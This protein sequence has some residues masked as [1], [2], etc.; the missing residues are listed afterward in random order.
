[1]THPARPALALGRRRTPEAR[2]WLFMRVSG[3]LL[4]LLVVGHLLDTAIIH[5][6]AAI[7]ASYTAKR[8]GNPFWRVWDGA[9][10]GLGL[11]HGAHGLRTIVDDHVAHPARRELAVTAI[12]VVAGVLL[13]LSAITVVSA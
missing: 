2:W 12:S 10:L 11:L 8:W 7:D 5:D 9:L 1:M 13:L 4:A 3:V 6:T